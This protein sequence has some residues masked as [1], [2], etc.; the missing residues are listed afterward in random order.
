M[1]L[2]QIEKRPEI[3]NDGVEDGTSALRAL[4]VV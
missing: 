3:G 2:G 1:G 4:T